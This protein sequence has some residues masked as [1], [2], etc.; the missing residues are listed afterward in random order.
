M[1]SK[2][3]LTNN[4]SLDKH[5]FSYNILALDKW[6]N[7]NL[8]NKQKKIH[9][10]ISL[11]LK[12]IRLID[13]LKDNKISN[14]E[15]YSNKDL[16]ICN[17]LEENVLQFITL[18]KPSKG[19]LTPIRIKER[20]PTK[21][22]GRLGGQI[23]RNSL[24]DLFYIS[25]FNTS[26]NLSLENT[27]ELYKRKNTYN[28]SIA[29][30]INYAALSSLTKIQIKNDNRTNKSAGLRR[31]LAIPVKNNLRSTMGPIFSS[32]LQ[33]GKKDY[34]SSSQTNNNKNGK[35]LSSGNYLNKSG[36]QIENS[37]IS[38]LKLKLG[39]RL[40]KTTIIPR[41]SSQEFLIGNMS[42]GSTSF[43]STSRLTY[44]NKR[45]AYS[46]TVKSSYLSYKWRSFFIK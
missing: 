33:I 30:L 38:G 27:A 8:F 14:I 4:T 36:G 43:I 31:Q 40:E 16:K 10:K 25:K 20:V 26:E 11:D 35:V 41:K 21:K 46:I 5:I 13:N 23:L 24:N 45:G 29:S 1:I 18:T 17:N 3:S 15:T 37:H 32:V 28:L 9:N 6:S 7:F 2:T 22:L 39:G 12:N 42:R 44:K 19:V 34:I